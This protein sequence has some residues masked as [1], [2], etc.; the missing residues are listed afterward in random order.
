MGRKGKFRPPSKREQAEA[1]SADTETRDENPFVSRGGLKLRRAL[2]AFGTSEPGP[3]EL[4]LNVNGLWCA[5]LGCST[6]GFSDCL[7]QAGA[8]RVYSVDTAYGELAWK[9]RTDER[10]VVMERTNAVHAEVPPEVIERG[11]VDL[12]VIDLGWTAQAKAIP[13]ALRWVRG[14]DPR[15]APGARSEHIS[16]AGAPQT[17]EP[18]AGEVDVTQTEHGEAFGV[19][20]APGDDGVRGRAGLIISLIKPHY[21]VGK[22]ELGEGGVLDAERAAAVT[23]EVL[24]AMPGLG[25]RVLGCV[26]SPVLGGKKKGK[27]T[28]NRE[29][30]ALLAP[31]GPED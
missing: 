23:D 12:V 18:S 19:F 6:G 10:V 20:M 31:I 9:V 15:L 22:D 13:A 24:A 16:G 30:L 11:G 21:E 28:G 25:V 8:G 14:G 3:D 1:A 2:D 29:W 7:L 26:E 5:D 17:A 27:G 4:G